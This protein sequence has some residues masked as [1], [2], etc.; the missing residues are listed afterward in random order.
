VPLPGALFVR[1][2]L[3]VIGS[4]LHQNTVERVVT[5]LAQGE[6]DPRPVLT[7]VR[8]LEEFQGALDDLEARPSEFVKIALRP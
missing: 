5:M 6:V 8:P 7:E 1:K 2:E 3:E 4:R